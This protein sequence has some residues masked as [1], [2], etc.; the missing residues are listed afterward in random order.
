MKVLITGVAGFIGSA[1]AL[2]L[3]SKGF[4]VFG[5]DNIN[6]YYETDLKRARLKRLNKTTFFEDDIVKYDNIEKYFSEIKPDVVINLAAQAGVRFSID[7]PKAYLDSNIVGFF[8]ILELCKKFNV[9]HLIYASSSS[10]Y[11]ASNIMPLSESIKNDSPLN[12]YAASKKSNELMAYSYSSLFNI[13]TTGLRF[14]T[15]YGPWDRPDMAL[16]KFSRKIF[17]GETIDLYGDGL[18][19]RDFTYIDDIVN[20]IY[21]TV[22]DETLID[23][24]LFEIFNIGSGSPIEV[25]YYV[26]LIEKNLNLEANKN[27]LPMQLGDMKDTFADTTKIRDIYDWMPKMTIEK[28]IKNY[29]EWFFE[30][31]G[32]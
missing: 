16:T 29:A 17:S 9:D 26:S 6:T 4:E 27:Y 10:V 28:G 31:Y 19:T 23:R 30:Y 24:E 13:K 1:M 3:E 14:F 11:G 21:K 25:G 15:V 12:I 32:K 5:I 22:K 18:L 20:G 8:N 2:K 7:N